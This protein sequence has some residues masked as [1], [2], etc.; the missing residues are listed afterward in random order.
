MSDSKDIMERVVVS[1][2][3]RVEHV[4]WKRKCR[5]CQF[6]SFQPSNFGEN[7]WTPLRM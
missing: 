5:G 7:L 2:D 6:S 1:A 4:E 3:E